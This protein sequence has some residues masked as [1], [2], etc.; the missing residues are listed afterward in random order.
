VKDPIE[1]ALKKLTPDEMPPELMARL[2]AARSQLVEPSAKRGG[3]WQRWFLPLA[4]GGCAALVAFTWLKEQEPSTS[5]KPLANAAAPLPF[6]RQDFLVGAREMGVLVG[7]N[8]RPYRVMELEWM[9]QDTVRPN[10]RG[11]AV[12]VQTTRREVIPVA[13]EIF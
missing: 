9:E 7:P 10:E 8:M 5:P 13:M 11:P 2:T 4:A 12:L 3:F 6:E 1:E